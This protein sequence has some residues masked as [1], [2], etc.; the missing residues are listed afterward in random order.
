MLINEANSESVSMRKIKN[1]DLTK[2][3]PDLYLCKTMKRS[4]DAALLSR[5]APAG[6]NVTSSLDSSLQ[7]VGL[8]ATVTSSARG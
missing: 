8:L 7:A 4:Y 5:F 1:S 2:L 6:L 3:P